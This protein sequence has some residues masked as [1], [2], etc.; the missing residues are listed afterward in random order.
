LKN[1]R[2][3]IWLGIILGI[4]C[5]A[6]QPAG[7]AQ[8]L[9][10]RQA[11]DP[12]AQ[13]RQLLSAMTPEEKVGQLFM[14]TFHGRDVTSKDARIIDLI[15]NRHVGGVMLLSANDNFSGT[16][17]E[18]ADA[19]QMIMDLQTERWAASQKSVTNQ[20]GFSY[21]P[22]YVPLWIGTSQN[23]DLFP[24]D[25]LLSGVT[26]LP[27]EMAIGATWNTGEAEKMGTILGKELSALGINLLLGPS[28]DLAENVSPDS[29][30]DLGTQVFGQ[31]PFWVGAMGQAFIQGVHAGSGQKIGVIA[32][33]FPGIGAADRPPESEVSTVRKTQDQLIQNELVPFF[34]VTGNA[35]SV[36]ATADGLLLANVRYQGLQ[37]PIRSSTRPLSFDT[38]ALDQILAMPQIVNWRKGGG[39]LVSDNLGSPA[40]RK[41]YD[42]SGQDFDP[43]QVVRSAFLGGSDILYIDN[44]VAP[45]DADSYTTL[46]RIIDFFVQKYREDT[47][48]AQRVDA[49]VERILSLKLRLF[50]SFTL[51]NVIP[52]INLLKEVGVSQ[53]DTFELA[54]QAVT[55]IHPVQTDLS[56]VLPRPPDL[57]ERIL[58][59]TDVNTFYQCAQCPTEPELAVD[60]LQNVVMRLYGPRTGGQINAANLASFSFLD[61]KYFLD[62][63]KDKVP[64]N[65]ADSLNLADWVV[66]ALLDKDPARPESDAFRQL[67]ANR[68]ELLR[69]KKVV[70]F[71]FGSPFTLDATDISKLSAYYALYSKTPPFLEVAARILFQ[72]LPPAG[73]LPVSVIGAGYDLSIALSPE[74]NQVISLELDLPA[75]PSATPQGT[76]TATPNPAL[77]PAGTLSPVPTVSV[78][79][80]LPLRTGIIYDHNHNPVPDGTLV[81]FIFTVP[82]GE[83]NVSQQITAPTVNGIARASYRIQSGSSLEV[84][85]VS[86]PAVTSKQLRINITSSGVAI[87]AVTPTQP[88]PTATITP[89]LTST[90][91][92]TETVTPTPTPLPPP[93]PGPED[94]F[95]SLLVAWGAAAVFFFLGRA[96][97]SLR[98]AVRWGLLAAAGGLLVYTYLAAGLPGGQSLLESSGTGILVWLTLFGS[99]LGWLAGF[100]WQRLDRGQRNRY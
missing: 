81:N 65:L 95:I 96:T 8:A 73:A 48:F 6:V 34:A 14:V 90:P 5:S 53:P 58:F 16:Q 99:L 40:L 83:S 22:K 71:A 78:G 18:L 26:P 63:N 97:S 13:V 89:T 61:L 52:N 44:L 74:P 39:V 36:D 86:D 7:F 3:F 17:T 37:G 54:R 33:S 93:R 2:R 56:Q 30:H 75:S 12:A 80:M 20:Y 62:D 49:S 42:V 46:V 91:T 87:T 24:N 55:M 35:T 32:H 82:G 72:E 28:L 94:W 88:P 67:L 51:E 77:T 38:A 100:A 1:W 84:R 85:V 41:F 43:R 76:Q 92:P 31:N 10:P 11:Q 57:R 68:P 66:V 50:K 45:G 59:L 25:Q 98:W 21:I 47:A 64:V 9:P 70:V 19:Y 29:T 15:S 4:L 27:S 79:D 60:A 69:N 23:G